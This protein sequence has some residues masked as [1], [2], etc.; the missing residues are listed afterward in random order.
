MSHHLLNVTCPLIQVDW[1]RGSKSKY[2]FRLGNGG[3]PSLFHE[4]DVPEISWEVLFSSTLNG[5]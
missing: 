1:V 3:V 4:H 5:S 2:A